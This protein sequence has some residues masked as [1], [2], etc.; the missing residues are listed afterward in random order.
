MCGWE[1]GLGTEPASPT[2]HS[3][4]AQGLQNAALGQEADGREIGFCGFEK[5]GCGEVMG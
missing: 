3:G 5:D 2:L 1:K 4:R